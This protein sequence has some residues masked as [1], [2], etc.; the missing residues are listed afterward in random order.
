MAEAA[1]RARDDGGDSRP[2]GRGGEKLCRKM[3]GSGPRTTTAPGR[4]SSPVRTRRSRS[5]AP[6]PRAS[7]PDE[8]SASRSRARS[9]AR[10][11]HARPT[12][13]GRRSKACASR[14]RR[15]PSCP[16]SRR[17]S[18]LR[19]TSGLRRSAH[20]P[21]ALHAGRDR[22]I[23]GGVTTFVEVGPGNVLSGLVNESTRRQDHSVN[24]VESRKRAEE[25]LTRQDRRVLLSRGED[26]AR[27]GGLA[28]HRPRDRQG[29]GARRRHGRR[30][31][32]ERGGQR[33]SLANEIGGRTVQ[34]DVSERTPRPRSSR[35]PATSTSSSTT[36]A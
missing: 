19:R 33:E 8:R 4:S 10:S 25:A 6:R 15:R 29:A 24:N 20:R 5:A 2:R 18:S 23:R 17:R 36:P 35:R 34:A 22:V 9:T 1:R 11:S 32:P 12:G 21:G 27:H 30:L 16:R 13:S 3:S 7:A 28:R 31:V 26:R 14:A